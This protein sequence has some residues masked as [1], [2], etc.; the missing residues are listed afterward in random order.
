MPLHKICSKGLTT[1]RFS[2]FTMNTEIYI[3]P[4]VLGCPEPQW[5]AELDGRKHIPLGKVSFMWS[6]R[7]YVPSTLPLAWVWVCDASI[8]Q[9]TLSGT[10]KQIGKLQGHLTR[11]RNKQAQGMELESEIQYFF[12]VSLLVESMVWRSSYRYNSLYPYVC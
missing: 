4:F 11:W 2:W 6:S 12:I 10:C 3:F 9:G 7:S 8:L 5:T 1:F